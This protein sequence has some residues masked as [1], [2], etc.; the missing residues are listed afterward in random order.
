MEAYKS[1]ADIVNNWYWKM[2]LHIM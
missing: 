2:L 1:Q